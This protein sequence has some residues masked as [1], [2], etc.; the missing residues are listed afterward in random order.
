MG[1]GISREEVEH[2]ARLAR[3]ALSEE[4]KALYGEQLG[5]IL[6]HAA[7]VTSLDTEGVPPTWHALALANVFRPDEPGVPAPS[8]TQ[9]EALA[10][11]PQ[12]EAG[13]FRVPRIL[14]AD[15]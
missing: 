6:E 2:V 8:L 13:H 11:G 1:T 4:E 3:L 12:V 7:R 10:N 14:E 9:Q 5:R 15:E